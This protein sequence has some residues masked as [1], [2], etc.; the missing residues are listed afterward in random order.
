MVRGLLVYTSVGLLR[1]EVKKMKRGTQSVLLTVLVAGVAIGG[2]AFCSSRSVSRPAVGVT[3]DS[4]Q[5]IR[6]SVIKVHTDHGVITLP[7]SADTWEEA[8]NAIFVAD[9]IADVQVVNN[10][11]PWRISYE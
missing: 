5:V 7:G 2:T 4:Q 6:R 3:A 10:E 9:S 1:R 8:E 11:I